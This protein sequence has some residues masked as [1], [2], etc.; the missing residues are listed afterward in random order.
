MLK[1]IKRWEAQYLSRSAFW[2]VSGA[3]A[4]TANLWAVD[5]NN[6]LEVWQKP[7]GEAGEGG[8]RQPK[9]ADTPALTAIALTLTLSAHL[10][11]QADKIEAL[12]K[13]NVLLEEVTRCVA[14]DSPVRAAQVPSVLPRSAAHSAAC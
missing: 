7:L 6:R 14:A 5:A 10:L 8:V 13:R 4:V 11:P 2:I 9:P 1:A 12:R 3:V